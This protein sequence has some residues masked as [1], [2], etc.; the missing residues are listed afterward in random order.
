MPLPACHQASGWEE[1]KVCLTP[2]PLLPRPCLK[3]ADKGQL[4]LP[5]LCSCLTTGQVTIQQDRVLGLGKTHS[6]ALGGLWRWVGGLRPSPT[7][8]GATTY[9]KSKDHSSKAT[10][11]E[12]FPG[13]LRGQLW[14][15][16][17]FL[18]KGVFITLALGIM[19]AKK[20]FS[21]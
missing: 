15:K 4:A 14:T 11:N 17:K 20:S 5:M 8:P 3:L 1:Y 13:L 16:S 18:T 6:L 7:Q 10:P 19:I 9:Q 21:F 12:A 2:A